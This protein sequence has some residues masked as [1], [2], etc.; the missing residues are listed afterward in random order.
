MNISIKKDR[1]FLLLLLIPLGTT[2]VL[3][4]TDTSRS[5][6]LT[7]ERKPLARATRTQNLL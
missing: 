3:E 1:N 2:V 4:T 5:A 6:R 7:Q